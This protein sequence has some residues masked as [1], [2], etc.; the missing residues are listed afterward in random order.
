MTKKI[1]KE[2]TKQELLIIKKRRRRILLE[3]TLVGKY[4]YTIYR[5]NQIK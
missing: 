3:K 5:E 1:I 4:T 2:N